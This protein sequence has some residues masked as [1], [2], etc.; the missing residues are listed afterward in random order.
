MKREINPVA[1]RLNLSG[2]DHVPE[3]EP[4]QADLTPETAQRVRRL[5]PDGKRALAII[6]EIDEHSK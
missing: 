4:E 6:E 1:L 3:Y 2:Y 5:D